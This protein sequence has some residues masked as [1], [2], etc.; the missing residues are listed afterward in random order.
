MIF[1]VISQRARGSPDFRLNDLQAH[2]R[3]DIIPRVILSAL[4]SNFIFSE[5]QVELEIYCIL[6]GSEPHG[7][8]Y[9]S[10]KQKVDIEDQDEIS[11]AGYIKDNWE[12]HWEKGSLNDLI[13]QKFSS[14]K[15]IESLQWIELLET[16]SSFDKFF[17]SKK[18]NLNKLVFVL[19]AQTDL[20]N[21]DYSVL[22]TYITKRLSI[23]TTPLLASQVISLTKSHLSLKL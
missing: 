11:L 17:E 13:E 6:K 7:W 20:T 1:L 23:G 3:F 15:S 12:K 2:G 4:R 18:I 10:D 9:F 19:G 5:N 16:G 22:G 21:E 14:K 8:L